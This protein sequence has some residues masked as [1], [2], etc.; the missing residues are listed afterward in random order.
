MK[1]IRKLANRKNNKSVQSAIIPD[2]TPKKK[3]I[4]RKVLIVKKPVEKKKNQPLIN[5]ITRTSGRPNGFKRCH[6]SI[7]NQSYSNI[8]HIVSID[9]LEDVEY[10]KQYDVDYFFLDKEKIA[11]QPDIPDPK[12]GKRFI[13]NL[14]F[15]ELFDKV[16][17]GWIMILDDDDYL[18]NNN[19]ILKMVDTIKSNTDMLIFQMKY[20]TGSV[21]PTLQ[22][23]GKKPRLARIGSPCI[24]V[25][26][27]IAKTI[28]WDGWKC[29]DYRYIS[30]V[31]DKTGGKRWIKQPLVLLG[32]G[33]GFGM[34]K[35][36]SKQEIPSSPK[37]FNIDKTEKATS[38]IENFVVEQPTLKKRDNTNKVLNQF[39]KK[40]KTE[41]KHNPQSIYHPSSKNKLYSIDYTFNFFKQKLENGENFTYVRY[42]DNDFMHIMGINKGRPLGN[43]RTV[44]TKELQIELN[45][46]VRIEDPNYF[47][48]YNFGGW[49]VKNSI[50]KRNIIK[51]IDTRLYK[52]IKSIDKSDTNFPVLFFYTIAVYYPKYLSEFFKYIKGSDKVMYVG[53]VDAKYAKHLLG[54]VKTY[55]KTPQ[56]NSTQFIQK[57][58]KDVIQK[59][60]AK[61]HKYIILAAGQ[62][63]RVLAGHIFKKYGNKYTIL[64]I[65]GLI[66]AFNPN[67]TKSTIKNNRTTIRN[68]IKE[69]PMV[70][71]E[72]ISLTNTSENVEQAENKIEE[73]TDEQQKST[74]IG[75]VMCTWQRIERLAKTLKMLKHQTYK[76]FK[77]YIW[78]NN[79]KYVKKIDAIVNKF[80]TVNIEVY[81]SPE[82]VGGIGRFMCANRVADQH[83]MFLFFDDDQ[84]FKPDY[85]QKMVNFYKP[86]TLTSWFG[87]KIEKDYYWRTRIKN[88]GAVDYCGTGGLLAD[89]NLF[90]DEGIFD[91]PEKYHFIEDLW[92]SYYAKYKHGYELRGC[93]V[94]MKINVDGKDQ[95]VNRPNLRNLKIEF[96]R[97]LEKTFNKK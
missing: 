44:F 62:L 24:M 8:R 33:G 53:G 91:I 34:R 10:V 35:D 70:N 5:I 3:V 57:Y 95:F 83:E 43:N 74:K 71:L 27:G 13:Y 11:A 77:F 17:E 47:R 60:E 65:G 15:N 32:S 85:I 18:A 23:M 76:D 55:I 12:T 89:A 2:S 26:S 4:D 56:K 19:A 30:R 40:Y 14:Y 84:E 58:K 59:L 93:N 21:L 52:F 49:S 69:I 50:F 87:W 79:Q 31:W 54:D 64:D 72:E 7:L 80:A 75:V 41:V 36:I 73:Q 28:R 42:G 1:H 68:N 37:D 46:S 22:E 94:Y 90:K 6:E 29:G 9:R 51:P 88:L 38:E 45:N 20:P 97:Y 25:H 61:E 81:H 48:T 66:E 82:N 16:E 67:S 78:N 86:K 39:Q 96:W 63:S 92:L